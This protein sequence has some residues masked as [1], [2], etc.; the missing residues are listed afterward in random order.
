MTIARKDAISSAETTPLSAA[1]RSNS[2]EC[3]A[4]LLVREGRESRGTVSQL[5]LLTEAGVG[6][7]ADAVCVHALAGGHELG[8]D[9]HRVKGR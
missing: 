7:K 5:S 3:V 8:R 9:V 6:G 2:P 1:R 4:L